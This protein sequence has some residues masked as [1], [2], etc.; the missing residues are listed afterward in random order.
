MKR[1]ELTED[2]DMLE[3]PVDGRW[4]RYEDVAPLLSVS[5][6][7]RAATEEMML[8]CISHVMQDVVRTVRAANQALR[9]VARTLTADSLAEMAQSTEADEP[10]D[11]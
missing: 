7:T 9:D 4:V 1:Y 3:A 6:D 10:S 2:G 8:L 5:D 11:E